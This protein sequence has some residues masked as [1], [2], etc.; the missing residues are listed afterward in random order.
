MT[1]LRALLALVLCAAA[2]RAEEVQSLVD[3]SLTLRG[4]SVD[5]TLHGGYTSSA[6]AAGSSSF[7]GETVALGVDF[8]VTDQV[9]FGVAGALPIHPGAAFGSVLGTALY[10]PDPAYAIRIDA[11]FERIGLNG[12]KSSFPPG[13]LVPDHS[14][15]YL[16][17][18]GAEIKLPITPAIAFVTGRN[19]A[20]Q[21]GHYSNIGDNGLGYYTGASRSTELSSDFLVINAGD[22]G[23][24]I[25]GVNL[26]AGLMLQPDPHFA[27]TLQAGYSVA[28][29]MGGSATHYIPIGLEAMVTPTPRLDIGTRFAIDGQ[30]GITWTRRAS[31]PRPPARQR[32]SNGAPR[33]P[34]SARSSKSA[35]RAQPP[36]FSLRFIPSARSSGG[37]RCQYPRAPPGNC[38]RISASA[39]PRKSRRA[40]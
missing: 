1:A 32:R 27:L 15:R 37:C 16:G 10:S 18:V 8:G 9:Q 26:P 17:G 38:L 21:F 12:D 39:A 31:H 6:S 23:N 5:L 14:N 29:N 24:T 11:G 36:S 7:D 4:G 13:A 3:R 35:G 2:A 28:I 34:R 30:I 22:G 33:T 40:T 19:G 25:L 20:V